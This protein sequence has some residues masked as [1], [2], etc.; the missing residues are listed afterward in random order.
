MNNPSD[1]GGGSSTPL[2]DFIHNGGQAPGAVETL[3]MS[4]LTPGE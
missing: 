2:W 1:W 3:T 4:D